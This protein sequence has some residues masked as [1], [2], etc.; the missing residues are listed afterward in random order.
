MF[1]Q[2]TAF[3]LVYPSLFFFFLDQANI[4]GVDTINY[5]DHKYCQMGVGASLILV[6]YPR[7]FV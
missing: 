5:K 1:L 7:I 6:S 3:I 2:D 4:G